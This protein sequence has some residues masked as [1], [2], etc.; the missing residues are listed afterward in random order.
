MTTPDLS[1]LIP[2]KWK[3]WAAGI[4]ALLTVVVPYV[5]EIEAYLPNPWPLVIGVV[6]AVLGVL[7]VYHAPYTPTGAVIAP[8]PATPAEPVTAAPVSAPV[9]VRPSGEYPNPWKS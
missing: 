9:A 5:I 3:T 6:I 8:A 2:L 4:G 1:S 7:G